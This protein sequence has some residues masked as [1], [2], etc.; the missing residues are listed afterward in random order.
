MSV[1]ESSPQTARYGRLRYPSDWSVVETEGRGPFVTKVVFGLPDGSNY[2]WEQR[3]HRKGHGPREPS[4]QA[5][6]QA[7]R[8]PECGHGGL[9]MWAPNRI[10]WWVAVAFVVGSAL[11]ALGASASLLPQAF[12]GEQTA[13]LVAAWCNWTGALLYTVSL[14]LWLLEGINAS[15]S[16]GA[17]EDTS[18]QRFAWF[19][20]QPRRLEFVAPFVFLVGSVLFNAE[21]TLVV[22]DEL[23]W[24][25]LPLAIGVLAFVG[26]V[27]FVVP[28]Y[29]QLIEISHRFLAWQPRKLSWWVVMLFIL[30]SV[31][32]LVGAAFGLDFVGLP[33]PK[34]VETLGFLAGAVLFLVGSY[35]MITELAAE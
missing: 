31:G 32:F 7:D 3:R 4:G 11:F 23:G 30:G 17:L 22:A 14:Y 35:L 15:D 29:L 1:S 20:W 18:N 12:G 21:T 13:P 16:L 9:W 26:A 33:T 27:L 19:A 5:A 6:Q 24:L 25:E 28:S 2:V 34:T 10:S 8:A